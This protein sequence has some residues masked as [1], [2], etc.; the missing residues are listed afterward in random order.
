MT[1]G[2]TTEPRESMTAGEAEMTDNNDMLVEL[3]KA[4]TELQPRLADVYRDRLQQDLF[5]SGSQ[6]RPLSVRRIAADE[7]KSLWDYLIQPD[8]LRPFE[9]GAQLVAVGLNE[10]TFFQILQDTQAFLRQHLP[11]HVHAHVANAVESYQRSL[12]QGFSAE[13]K[14][15]L[16]DEQ[17]RMRAAFERTLSRYTRELELA[18]EVAR[19][20]TSIL[21]LNELLKTVSEHIRQSFNH[22]FAGVFLLDEFGKFAI[23]RAGTGFAGQELLRRGY[24]VGV[25]DD[26][27]VGWCAA[28]GSVRIGHDIGDDAVQFNTPYLA[29]THS[30]IVLPLK[31]RG[32]L[33]GVLS[34]QSRHVAAFTEQDTNALRVVADQLAYAIENARLFSQAQD[35]LK[36]MRATQTA[37]LNRTWTGASPSGA[38]LYEQSTDTFKTAPDLWKPESLPAGQQQPVV[39]HSDG[40]DVSGSV[41]AL[42]LTLRDQLIGT[43]DL[44]DLGTAKQWNDQD[45]AL[46]QAVTAQAAL[47]L[48][49]ARLLQ[50]TQNALA[51][52]EALYVASTELNMAHSYD[53]VL[54]VLRRNTLLGN[55]AHDVYIGYFD[56]HWM[57]ESMPASV[58]IISRWTASEAHALHSRYAL[59]SIPSAPSLLRS[60]LPTLIEDVL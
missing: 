59:N 4:R 40:A 58:E 36:A 11:A 53:D 18:A 21:D 26:S 2:R 14:R 19:A 38:Y 10:E 28:Q 44:Y 23:L 24:K 50:G 45:V 5:A 27:L 49:N 1:S 54:A 22:S 25:G 7:A 17:E 31:L 12:I 16:L 13:R 9:Q 39:V 35:S 57:R 42:P 8:R 20:A 37:A 46:A 52:T 55:G 3:G 32:D 15:A 33:I 51:D 30:E 60:D 48:E 56:R 47:A 6:M 34:V 43:I 41:L 29:D